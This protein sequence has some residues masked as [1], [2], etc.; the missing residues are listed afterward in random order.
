MPMRGSLPWF[1]GLAC[2]IGLGACSYPEL[3]ELGPPEFLSCAELQATCGAGTDSCCTSPA[4]PGGSYDRSYDLAHDASSGTTNFPAT[5]TSF[6]LDKYEVTVGRFRA[7]VNAGMGT[8]A[9]TP[10]A[11]AG[12][13]GR[14]AGSG[15]DS[16]WDAYLMANTAALALAVKCDPTFQT[17]TDTAAA[18]EHRP[19]RWRKLAMV[20]AAVKRLHRRGQGW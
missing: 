12:A 7:F 8:Q 11:S 9:S 6:R 14:I 4:V 16:K 2:M 13:H 15:W 5:V 18:N 3:P 20:S 1:H 10:R 17:W 19:A